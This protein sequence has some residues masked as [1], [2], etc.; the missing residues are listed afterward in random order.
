MWFWHGN[1]RP[2]DWPLKALL[3]SSHGTEIVLWLLSSDRGT[4][5]GTGSVG[6]CLLPALELCCLHLHTL[7]KSNHPH[8]PRWCKINPR[9]CEYV[10]DPGTIGMMLV[11][12]LIKNGMEMIQSSEYSYKTQG[13]AWKMHKTKVGNVVQAA[14][15]FSY[16]DR[17]IKVSLWRNLTVSM[18]RN[19]YFII[20]LWNS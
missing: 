9:V 1:C 15:F 8:S 6:Y 19:W 7:L 18:S 13:W 10:S 3:V 14:F 11:G 4:S 17:Y 2:L 20:H 16:Y 5:R 12:V